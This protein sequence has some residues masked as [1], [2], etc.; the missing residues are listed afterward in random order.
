MEG[1]FNSSSGSVVS[2]IGAMLMFAVAFR[3][4]VCTARRISINPNPNP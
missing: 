3:L 1:G 4:N 2:G